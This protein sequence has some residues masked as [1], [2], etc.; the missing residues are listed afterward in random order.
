MPIYS[1]FGMRS[2]VTAVYRKV[3]RTR[4][5]DLAMHTA[6]FSDLINGLIDT[7]QSV[8]FHRRGSVGWSEV[9]SKMEDTGNLIMCTLKKMIQ[10][11]IGQLRTIAREQVLGVQ[12]NKDLDDSDQ[13]IEYF[14]AWP[15]PATPAESFTGSSAPLTATERYL[16][17]GMEEQKATIKEFSAKLKALQDSV[18]HVVWQSLPAPLL[19]P[20][21][22]LLSSMQ[23]S[24][25][26]LDCWRRHIGQVYCQHTESP[27]TTD[28]I[29]ANLNF[30]GKGEKREVNAVKFVSH[31]IFLQGC[32]FFQMQSGN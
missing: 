25:K 27:P 14:A 15:S 5:G 30:C 4:L 20:D 31:W 13:G 11:N 3:A 8:V 29:A 24:G 10:H 28:S 21:I 9:M 22:L 26:P 32:Y 16:I 18:V 17:C 7:D 12:V 1:I 19:K 6:S 2:S 23:K